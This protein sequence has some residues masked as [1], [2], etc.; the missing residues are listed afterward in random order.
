MEPI[1]HIMQAPVFYFTIL[2][3][4]LK[5]IITSQ[6]TIWNCAPIDKNQIDRGKPTSPKQMP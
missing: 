4:L 5:L 2:V 1:L 3:K 6:P